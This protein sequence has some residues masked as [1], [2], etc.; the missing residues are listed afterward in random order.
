MSSKELHG[1]KAN[2]N[3]EV[4]CGIRFS[5]GCLP[6]RNPTELAPKA[7]FGQV[8]RSH[9]LAEQPDDGGFESTAVQRDNFDTNGSSVAFRESGDTRLDSSGIGRGLG[10]TDGISNDC[11]CKSSDGVRTCCRSDT[12]GH[13]GRAKF[14]GDPI[15]DQVLGF[16][17]VASGYII[18]FAAGA[19]IGRPVLELLA[20]K[21]LR[22]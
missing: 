16:L 3:N 2:Q 8:E 22:K 10:R 14:Q 20:S 7:D 4:D 9:N 12:D 13:S 5:R 19:W 17:A 1:L 11:A 6:V 21:I 15:M 18:S